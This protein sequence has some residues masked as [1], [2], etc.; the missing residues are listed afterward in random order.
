LLVLGFEPDGFADRFRFAISILR[1]L[2]EPRRGGALVISRMASAKS[3]IARSRSSSRSTPPRN[4]YRRKECQQVIVA[5]AIG[6]VA[7]CLVEVGNGVGIGLAE[8]WRG[9]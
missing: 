6:V 3:A 7:N 4:P 1:W 5:R 2:A 9:L 8:R